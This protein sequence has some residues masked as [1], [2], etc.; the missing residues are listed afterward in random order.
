MKT[1]KEVVRLA[2]ALLIV[3]TS[4]AFGQGY[5]KGTVLWRAGVPVESVI[6]VTYDSLNVAAAQ[7]TT[8]AQGNFDVTLPSGLYHETFSRSG[9]RDTIQNDIRVTD[10]DTTD[11]SVN[12]VWLNH[13]YYFIGD[14]NNS[15]TFTGLDVTYSVSYLRGG[16]L[17]PYS[18]ECT[19]GHIW[20]VAGD[21]NGS[22]SFNGVDVTYMVNYF[23]RGEFISH[24]HDCPPVP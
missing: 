19:P 10:D 22:C 4:T 14:V 13:C 1:T 5:I 2:L 8:D 7:D 23:H 9:Y 20:Y 12:M 6:L 24:C 17:P 21:V 3:V 11:I 18:C 16:C 15:D